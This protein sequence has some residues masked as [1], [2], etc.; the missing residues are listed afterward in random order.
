MVF[1]LRPNVN[2]LFIAT[3]LI[4]IL[5]KLLDVCKGILY[6]I[7]VRLRELRLSAVGTEKIALCLCIG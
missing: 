6:E 7:K 4:K 3:R 5:S 1:E 2:D